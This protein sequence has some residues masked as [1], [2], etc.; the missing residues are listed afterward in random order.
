MKCHQIYEFTEDKIGGAFDK[1]G[2]FVSRHAWK[3][4]LVAIAVNVLL[5]I[6]VLKLNSN[7]SAENVY[8]PHGECFR[9]IF[10][11]IS[12]KLQQRK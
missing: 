12:Y 10:E 4:I 8:L 3:V 2:R 1:Y 9:N 6:G 5:G 11:I 7:I